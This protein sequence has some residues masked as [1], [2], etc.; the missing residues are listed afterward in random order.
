VPKPRHFSAG[1][2]W[3]SFKNFLFICEARISKKN[4]RDGEA[5]NEKG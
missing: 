5:Q 1:F 2:F 3:F 4:F